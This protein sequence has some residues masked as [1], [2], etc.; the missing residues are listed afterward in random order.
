[1]SWQ[2]YVDT[3]LVGS[4]RVTHAAIIGLQGGVWAS[5]PGFNLTAEEQQALISA[6]KGALSGDE[7]GA[8]QLQASGLRL[9]NE[10]YFTLRV[11]ERSAYLKKQA[12]GAIVVKTKQAILVAVYVAPL[13]AAEATP[14]VESLADYLVSVG[15]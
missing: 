11:S 14:V 6:A 4:G 9:Q 12:D 10:K 3:N 2:T 1:M 7:A 8:S 13:Q 15:Y 5:S